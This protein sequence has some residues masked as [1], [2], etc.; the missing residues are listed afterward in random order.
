MYTRLGSNFE[1]NQRFKTKSTR[2]KRSGILIRICTLRVEGL[3][4][5]QGST[6]SGVQGYCSSQMGKL[7]LQNLLEMAKLL[8]K[9]G[10]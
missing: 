8:Q 9:S 10:L 2:E 5:V 1:L 3:T 4:G 6:G 7:C